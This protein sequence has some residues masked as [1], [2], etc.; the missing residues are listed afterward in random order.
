MSNPTQAVIRDGVVTDTAAMDAATVELYRS[1]GFVELV[2]PGATL[3]DVTDVDP[4]PGIGWFYD[5]RTFT[6]PP[7][8]PPEPEPEPTP[9]PEPEPT[10]EV[11]AASPTA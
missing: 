7:P 2:W 3:V 11:P 5:G 9:A 6:A 1:L 8:P 10:A 4:R